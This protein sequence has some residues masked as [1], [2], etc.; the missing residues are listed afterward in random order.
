LGQE[1]TQIIYAYLE[2]NHSIQKH[3]IAKKLDSFN[4]ALEEFL[5]TGAVVIE[6]AIQEILELGGLEENRGVDFSEQNRI[7]KLA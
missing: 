5:G 2:N 7:I 6:K 4:H 1:A 3:E